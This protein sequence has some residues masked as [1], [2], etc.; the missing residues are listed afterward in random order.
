MLDIFMM[1]CVYKICKNIKNLNKQKKNQVAQSPE[2]AQS[3]VIDSVSL[4]DDKK[5]YPMVD[6]FVTQDQSSARYGDFVL[7]DSKLFKPNSRHSYQNRTGMVVMK[8]PTI[9]NTC[10]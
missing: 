1:V 10:V 3:P 4:S 9:Y 6:R 5:L 8:K 2:V 7:S